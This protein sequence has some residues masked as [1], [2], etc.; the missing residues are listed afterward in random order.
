LIKQ[1][2]DLGLKSEFVVTLWGA[3]KNVVEAL[4]RTDR[5]SWQ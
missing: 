3:E 5:D 4:G 1:C 2:R